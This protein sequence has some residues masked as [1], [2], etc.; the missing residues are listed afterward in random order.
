MNDYL[1]KLRFGSNGFSTFITS[2]DNT[3]YN[4]D[5]HKFS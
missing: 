1:E 2:T 4:P 3:H 5:K